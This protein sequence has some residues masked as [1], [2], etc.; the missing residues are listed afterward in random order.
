MVFCLVILAATQYAIAGVTAEEAEQLKTTL[1]PL[2]AERAGNQDGT[3][4]AWTGGVTTAPPNYK[5]FDDLFPDDKILF[6]I[7][8]KNMDQY[9]D[10]LSIGTQALLKKYPDTYHVNVYPSHRS[11]ARTQWVYD[12]TFKNATRARTE[13]DGE[14]VEGAYGGVPFPIP[15][16]AKEC[17]WNNQLTWG[18]GVSNWMH[19]RSYFVTG[20]G[21]R[22]L[23]YEMQRDAQWKYYDPKGSVETYK[24]TLGDSISKVLAPPSKAG[25][26]M[27]N[28]IQTNNP[29]YAFEMYQYLSGQR[30][31][32]RAPNTE[33][34]T[35]NF[36]AAGINFFDEL[37]LQNG[38][39]DL[40]DWK[41]LGKKEMYIPYNVSKLYTCPL[42]EVFNEHHVNPDVLRY[43][44]HRVW[45]VE[46][47]LK[48]GKRHMVPKRIYCL[49]E[50]AW[51]IIFYDG[52]DKR[53]KHWKTGEQYL[54]HVPEP[55]IVSQPEPNFT[56]YDL[57]TGYYTISG[58]PND[59]P[60]PSYKMDMPSHPEGLF[61]EAGL[62]SLGVD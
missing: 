45:V 31:V 48:P 29:N 4:P 2:G 59:L 10:K 30:R 27:L 47:T 8:A 42:N 17:M 16:T 5:V 20:E 26:L 1:T 25:E 50:D 24:G 23:I 28:A 34:D 6:V 39:M 3:I 22:T 12:N 54:F 62:L 53:E 55:Y 51:T 52:W 32:K 61:S 35:P 7:T 13:N 60:Q 14:T 57:N 36:V 41:I 19:F 38:K 37:H 44:L 33:Y 15:K 46:A 11:I 40:F 18:G 56:F 49:D 21:K 58:C 43:E 9:A